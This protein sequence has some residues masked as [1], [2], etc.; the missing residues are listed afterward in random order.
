MGERT[1]APSGNHPFMLN[2][3][4]SDRQFLT[5]TAGVASA[6][7]LPTVMPA[8]EREKKLHNSNQIKENNP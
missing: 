4:T 5:A 6:A 7:S 8:A 2:V 1:L 3:I